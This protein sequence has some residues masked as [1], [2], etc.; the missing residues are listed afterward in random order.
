MELYKNQ[1]YIHNVTELIITSGHRSND[2]HKLLCD[3][4]GQICSIVSGHSDW[5]Y[6]LP[7]AC[8]KWL[9]VTNNVMLLQFTQHPLEADLL[10]CSVV[11]GTCSCSYM[12]T[13]TKYVHSIELRDTQRMEEPYL[14]AVAN[15]ASSSMIIL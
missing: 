8:S 2:H 14:H 10:V 9:V 7:Q 5:P 11:C 12:C 13:Y 3:V 4:A 1:G 6:Y 15:L